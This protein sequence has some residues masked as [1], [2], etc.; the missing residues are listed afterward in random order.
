MPGLLRDPCR[1]SRWWRV[2]FVLIGCR[3]SPD[4]YRQS[5]LR[6]RNAVIYV[7][8]LCTHP[9]HSA[10]LGGKGSVCMNGPQTW[11]Q[12]RS[13][14]ARAA[15]TSSLGA[16]NRLFVREWVTPTNYIY[17]FASEAAEKAVQ[18]SHDPETLSD[19][20][21]LQRTDHE[22]KR[23]VFRQTATETK[24][25]DWSLSQWSTCWCPIGFQ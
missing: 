4:Q 12:N 22:Q 3:N 2:S 18:P 19:W 24:W 8:L 6:V 17:P 25:N 23:D 7:H 10:P 21:Q 15:R 5:H 14:H 20:L 9:L 1:W 13:V 16:G 11:S